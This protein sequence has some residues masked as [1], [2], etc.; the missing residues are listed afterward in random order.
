MDSIYS[1]HN[2]GLDD[3]KIVGFLLGRSY[4]DFYRIN[5]LY[6]QKYQPT[7]ISPLRGVYWLKYGNKTYDMT[8]EI[9]IEDVGTSY[10]QIQHKN[11]D[12]A[13]SRE[14]LFLKD[15]EEDEIQSYEDSDKMINNMINNLSLGRF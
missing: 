14:I 2:T 7:P 5:F 3:S 4:D 6:R 11:N 8:R 1:W 13:P 10:F 9:Y 12:I 15:L